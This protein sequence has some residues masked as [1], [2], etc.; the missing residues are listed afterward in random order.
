MAGPVVDKLPS[1]I[2]TKDNPTLE[3]DGSVVVNLSS[4]ARGK[5]PEDLRKLASQIRWSL[6]GHPPVTLTIEN[7][8]DTGNDSDGY[9]SDNAAVVPGGLDQEK[10]VVARRGG[11]P[12]RHPGRRPARAVRPGRVEH[13]R[14]S[15]PPSTGTAPRRRWSA[16]PAT[17][18]QQL[19][20][21]AADAAGRARRSTSTDQ[22]PRRRRAEPA[23]VD[24][25]A[26][27][28]AS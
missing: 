10:F 21:S 8:K 23:G 16:G 18:Q 25:P 5:S 11:P 28:S 3:P 13:R 27:R 14:S 17:A 2:E 15:R 19:F 7:A 22:R 4:K 9:D 1:E 24:Q 6:A 12:G 26:R 20:V